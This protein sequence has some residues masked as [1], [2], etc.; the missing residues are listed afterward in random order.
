M[1]K[2]RAR[3][4]AGGNGG[5][6]RATPGVE[7]KE[8]GTKVRMRHLNAKDAKV[9]P[10]IGVLGRVYKKDGQGIYLI[11]GAHVPTMRRQGLVLA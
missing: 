4:R 5:E 10:G 8:T 11:D 3:G 7:A 9:C 2:K 6:L 1:A